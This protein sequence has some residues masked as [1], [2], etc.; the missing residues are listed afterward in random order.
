[1]G[2]AFGGAWMHVYVSAA[3]MGGAFGGAWMH[4]YVWLRPFPVLET[5]TTLSTGYTPIQNKKFEKQ[6]IKYKLSTWR[7]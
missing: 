1:M 5:I 4:V 2:G 3:W 7:L 6:K